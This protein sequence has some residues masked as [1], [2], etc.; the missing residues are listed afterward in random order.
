VHQLLWFGEGNQKMLL[1]SSQGQSEILDGDFR[2][3]ESFACVVEA[4]MY[5]DHQV[6]DSG[7]GG[8]HQ[9]LK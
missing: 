9:G 1:S 8:D 5:M 4:A 2:S 3:D 6:Q 7:A